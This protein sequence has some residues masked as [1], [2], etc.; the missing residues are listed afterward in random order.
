MPPR[1]PRGMLTNV[2]MSTRTNT[3]QTIGD[4]RRSSH[5]TRSRIQLASY[6]SAKGGKSPS[7]EEILPNP[8][9]LIIN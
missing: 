5:Q 2:M 9:E 3:S 8:V 6:P 7:F 4:K 1:S